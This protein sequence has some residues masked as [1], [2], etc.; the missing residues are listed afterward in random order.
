MVN[1]PWVS[2][3]A[4]R[5]AKGW[6][7]FR[8]AAEMNT[9]LTHLGN[10]E[11]GKVSPRIGT[12]QKAAAALGVPLNTLLVDGVTAPTDGNSWLRNMVREIIVEELDKR[13]EGAR[14]ASHDDPAPC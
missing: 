4:A 7:R 14:G 9:N 2:L 5:E 6:S 1:T 3:I 11:K 10:L 12:I 13:Q 8:L